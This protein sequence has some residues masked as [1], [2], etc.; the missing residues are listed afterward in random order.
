MQL[1]I[2]LH[3]FSHVLLPLLLLSIVLVNKE[4]DLLK[5]YCAILIGAFFPDLDHL[6]I[7]LDYRFKSFWHFFLYSL[8]TNRYRKSF[9]LFH[10]FPA[11][12]ILSILLPFSFALNFY[13]GIYFLAFFSHLSLDL[14]YDLFSLQKFS[15]WKMRKR[16]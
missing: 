1:K 12:L 16:I 5:A 9:L 8:K 13:L 3:N 7:F 15:H 4:I 11:I 6:K 10:N 14:F 2:F